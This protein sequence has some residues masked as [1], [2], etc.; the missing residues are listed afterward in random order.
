MSTSANAVLVTGVSRGIGHAIACRLAEE[1]YVVAGIDIDEAGP[2]PL[3]AFEQADMADVTA[4]GAAL[5][6]LSARFDFTR[7]V[8]NVGTSVRENLRDSDGETQRRLI[9][10]N[11]ASA[12]ASLKAVLPAMRAA[13]F[14]R[15]VNIT[16]RAVYGRDTR[17]AY[18]ATKSALT[19]MTKA[20]AIELA[21]AG[22]TVN[23]V[24]PG[25]IS[26]ELF[27]RNNPEGAPDVERLRGRIPMQRLG[28]TDEVA[29]A[30]SF[31]LRDGAGYITGQSLF[32]CGGLSI[33]SM[34]ADSP[35]PAPV[36]PKQP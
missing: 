31:F 23:A 18:A 29:E 22:I 2:P 14:G 13:G 6:R 35:A 28:R 25:M 33:G 4:A 8:N 11:L 36:T 7:L 20:W 5:E 10:L 9:R 30:V 15:I 3:A 17:S 32:V 1:G 34:L 21:P 26:T 27:H 19:A 24:G 12:V 16:S